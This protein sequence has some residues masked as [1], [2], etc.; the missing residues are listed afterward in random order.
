[1]RLWA[2]RANRLHPGSRPAVH[3]GCSRLANCDV[4]SS[5]RLRTELERVAS[6][7][8]MHGNGLVSTSESSEKRDELEDAR[9]RTVHGA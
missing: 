6:V 2:G 3:A 4:V 7:P 5:V 9:I 1:M 8:C